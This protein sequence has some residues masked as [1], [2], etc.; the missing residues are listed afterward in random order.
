MFEIIALVAAAASAMAAVSSVFSVF[1]RKSEVSDAYR[2]LFFVTSKIGEDD[3]FIEAYSGSV[4]SVASHLSRILTEAVDSMEVISSTP[5]SAS[6][7]AF[8]GASESNKFILKTIARDA[9]SMSDREILKYDYPLEDNRPYRAI[10]Y[11]GSQLYVDGEVGTMAEGGFVNDQNWEWRDGYR[12]I[13]VVPLCLPA[14][15]AEGKRYYGFLSFDS[16]KENAFSEDLVEVG[17]AL[18]KA[19]TKVV[20]RIDLADKDLGGAVDADRG[21]EI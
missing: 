8:S 12:S 19:V 21:Q 5:I 16:K 9:D 4:K 10:M 15:G 17:K 14:G 7:K 20:S 18:G 13:M 1:R 11:Q 2:N 3:F 6:I